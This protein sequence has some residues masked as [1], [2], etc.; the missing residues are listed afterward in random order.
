M[1]CTIG[2]G[3]SMSRRKAYAPGAAK[4]WW[5]GK[6]YANERQ[7]NGIRAAA[8]YAVPYLLTQCPLHAVG[9]GAR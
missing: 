1:R 2:A 7:G 5:Q 4:A 9:C 6:P 3:V 8:A